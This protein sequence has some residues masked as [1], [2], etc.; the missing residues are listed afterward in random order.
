MLT[1]DIAIEF[2]LSVC[3]TLALS[4][5]LCMVKLLQ[6]PVGHHLQFF[7][8]QTALRNSDI[9]TVNGALGLNTEKVKT[10]DYR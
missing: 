8:V 7:L 2:C 6:R 10:F 4:K 9:N 3:P 1:R 5:R